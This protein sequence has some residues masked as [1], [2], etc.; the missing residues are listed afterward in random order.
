MA[1]AAGMEEEE[2]NFKDPLPSHL[3]WENGS[4]SMRM[5]RVL[6]EEGSA[7]TYD[8]LKI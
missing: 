6:W 4:A 1:M 3:P 8:V 2:L 7:F 5:V